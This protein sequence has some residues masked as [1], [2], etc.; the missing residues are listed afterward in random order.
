M[1]SINQLASLITLWTFATGVPALT[2]DF[3]SPVTPQAPTYST[4]DALDSG[5]AQGNASNSSNLLTGAGATNAGVIGGRQY[6]LQPCK[7]AYWL[8]IASACPLFLRL[9]SAMAFLQPSLFNINPLASSNQYGLY[10]GQ[11]LPRVS[12]GSVDIN[13]VDCPYLRESYGGGTI[14]VNPISLT[15]NIPGIGNVNLQETPAN[16]LQFLQTSFGS[17]GGSSSGSGSSGGSLPG[18]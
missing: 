8:P 10:S 13:T 14:V 1:K 4:N 5:G 18:K 12:T 17:L 3:L 9:L 16:A 11:M 6:S 2:Q 7:T 15:I